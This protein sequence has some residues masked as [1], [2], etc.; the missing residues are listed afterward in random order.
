MQWWLKWYLQSTISNP[1]IPAMITI[2]LFENYSKCRIWIFQFWHFLP[3]FIKVDLSGNT[4]WMQNSGLLKTPQ[5]DHFWLFEWTFVVS[6]CK[7]SSLRSQC[8]MRLFLWFS[9][10]VHHCKFDTCEIAF[11]F[12]VEV[13]SYEWRFMMLCRD[14][15]SGKC[16]FV[17][18]ASKSFLLLYSF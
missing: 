1:N 9:N 2:I 7:R 14:V 11:Y 8:L 17:F 18:F 6:K 10:T 4:V 15:K 16:L 13:G 5:I 12:R 3:S